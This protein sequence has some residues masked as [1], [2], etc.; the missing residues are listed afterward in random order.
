MAK[1]LVPVLARHDTDGSITPIMVYWQDGKT[2]QIDKVIEKRQAA[3]FKS[4]GVGIRYKCLIR[5]MAYHL[6]DEQGVWFIEKV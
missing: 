4:G 3:S 5:G 1:T 6:F 2:F